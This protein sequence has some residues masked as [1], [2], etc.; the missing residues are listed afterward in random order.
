MNCPYCNH[1]ESKVTDS[2]DTGKYSIR[3]RRECLKCGKRFTTYESIEMEPLYVIKKDGRREKF[4]RNKIKNGIM[5]ALEKRPISHEKIDEIVD[6]IEEKIR[7]CG[8]EEVETSLIGEYVM[9]TLKQVDHVGYIR[10]A[11]VYRSFTDVNSFEKEV[12][13]LMKQTTK[14][15]K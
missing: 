6:S 4:D 1:I 11:S 2:R 5:K 12:K 14:K 9:E 8:K 10:F 7:R 13:N 3:R 15:E